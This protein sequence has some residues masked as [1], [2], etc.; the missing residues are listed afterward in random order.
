MAPA[1]RTTNGTGNNGDN[2]DD[3]TKRYVDESLAIQTSHG[4]NDESIL[5]KSSE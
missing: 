4:T 3:K 2:V 5:A 1:T